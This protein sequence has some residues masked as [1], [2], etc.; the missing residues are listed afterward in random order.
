MMEQQH[1]QIAGAGLVG[2]L[3]ALMLAQKGHKIDIFEAR[4]DSRKASNY[5]GRSINLALSDRG[6]KALELVGI[7]DK[8]KAQA[9]PMYKRVM[10]ATDGSL[11]EQYYGINQQAIYSVSRGGLNNQMIS[12]AEEH[13]DVSVHFDH[14]C[15]GVD[16]K[17][18]KLLLEN[19]VTGK[20]LESASDLIF[21]ADGAFSKVRLSMQRS[22]RFNY[23]QEYI[24][25]GYKELEIPANADGTHKL[26]K[27]ALHIWPRGEFMLIALPNLDGSFTCT[28][29]LPYEGETSFETLT[30][31]EKVH[32]FFQTYFPDTLDLIPDLVEDFYQ[33]PTSSLCIIRCFPWVREQTALIGDASHAIVPFYGQGMNSGFEDCSILHQLLEDND[34]WTSI[35]D[36]YQDLRKENADAIA[37]LAMYNFVEMR[38]KT[39]DP[40]FLL[41]KKIEKKL[42]KEHPDHWMPLYSMV[43]FS[44]IPYAEALEI[45]KKQSKIMDEVMAYFPNIEEVWDSKI[46]EDKILSL[47]Y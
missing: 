23:E 21:G 12:L 43:T 29:F 26:E 14:K 25:H 6:W 35:L 1:I 46:V 11:T 7:A 3:L 45:G 33:N 40:D 38:D 9:I 8:I 10:H 13:P 31:R 15:R 20:R 37:D 34:D 42:L 41:R 47:L 36:Q 4:T 24:D 2:S 16:L 18:T 32:T 5:S 27:N 19:K 22:N 44:H 17:N 28:L 39:A 30:S